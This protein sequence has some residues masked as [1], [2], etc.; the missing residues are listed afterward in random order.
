VAAKKEQRIR[1]FEEEMQMR[2]GYLDL[3]DRK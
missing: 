3:K 1:K 2:I